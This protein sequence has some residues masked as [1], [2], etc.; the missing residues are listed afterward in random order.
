MNCNLLPLA[1]LLLCMLPSLTY[2][3]DFH[4][5]QFYNAPL[6]LNPGL[7]GVF[8]GDTRFM[9]NYKSQWTDVPVDYQTVTLAMDKQ[10]RKVSNPDGFFAGGLAFNYDRSGDSRFNWLNL[11]LNGSYTRALSSQ[12]FLSFGVKAAVIQRSFDVSGLYFDAQ[13]DEG[14]GFVDRGLPTG[15]DFDNDS[16]IFPDFSAGLNLR[17]QSEQT[18]YL[19]F[20]NNR[21]SKIDLGVGIHHLTRPD[22][23]FY[24]SEE[25]PLERR[26]SPY[27]AGVLQVLPIVDV[28]GAL[29]YQTQGAYYEEMVGMLG[30]RLWISNKLG[31]Q[32]SLMAGIGMRR[33]I[34]EDALQD[35]YWPTFEV[36][37]N[38]LRVGLNYDFNVSEFDAATENKGGLELSVRYL[39][40]KARPLPEFKVCPLI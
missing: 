8:S 4:Y 14:R 2:G 9:A 26:I 19:V 12:V 6:H 37:Y 30:G 15:E 34:N 40:R 21:R 27:I 18:D 11:D 5:S 36:T 31:S 35:A 10:F 3:Q 32:I 16:N 28:V 33:G 29:N 38:T 24:E 25:V 39:I 7:T 13:F 20:R 23:A 17:L 1:A 22:Q